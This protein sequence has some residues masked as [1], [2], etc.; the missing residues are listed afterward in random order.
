MCEHI[1]SHI[2]REVDEIILYWLN[3]YTGMK[4]LG[5]SSAGSAALPGAPLAVKAPKKPRKLLGKKAAGK[6]KPGQEDVK[7]MHVPKEAFVGARK[8]F[9]HCLVGLISQ[10]RYSSQVSHLIH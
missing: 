10:K 2:I 3:I 6:K 4:D 8:G 5:T 9:I 1:S 7:R